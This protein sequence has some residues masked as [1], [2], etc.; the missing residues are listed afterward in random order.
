MNGFEVLQRM[1]GSNM[2][3]VIF[4]TAYDEFALQAFDANA[5]DY[6]LKPI[7]DDRL[8][9][10]IERVRRHQRGKQADEQRNK[11]L[12]FV[13]ELTGRETNARVG[14]AGGRSASTRRT[15]NA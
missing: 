15:Q 10:A 12:K 7:N 14:P 8:R 3:D 5:L 13:C 9:E 1:S 11:L 6:L 2:P 4:V